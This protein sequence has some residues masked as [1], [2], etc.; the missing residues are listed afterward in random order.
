M[1]KMGA[2]G[3]PTKRIDRAAEN[4][5]LDTL[6]ASGLGF[7]VLSEEIGEVLIGGN[8][9]ARARLFPA[10]RSSGR[11]L[12][13][14]SRHPLLL[15]LHLPHQ[16]RFSFRLY[17]RSGPGRLLIMPKQ[18]GAHMQS[19]EAAC[20]YQKI[21]TSPISASLLTP[22]GP[23]PAGLRPSAIPCAAFAP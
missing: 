21:A 7:K 4:A 11:H 3:T 9:P 20:T 19:R 12:Q 5:V 8:C 14:H 23:I 17:L 22:C 1:V 13:R 10:P 6:R 2:D 18:D 15:R 16:G